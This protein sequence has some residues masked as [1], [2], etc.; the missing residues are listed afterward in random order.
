MCILMYFG[1]DAFPTREQ[2]QNAVNNNPDGFGWAIVTFGDEGIVT[3]HTMDAGEAI[4]GFLRDRA[5]YPGESA[6]F[7]ARIA[8]HGSTSLDNCHPFEV[9]HRFMKGK[10]HSAVSGEMIL[11]HN[12]MLSCGPGK[13]DDRSDT[14]I[15]ADDI[16][17]R[18][19]PHLDS[20]K[21]RR[22][23]EE[24]MGGSKVVVL[25]TDPAYRQQSYVFNSKLGH[26]L[27]DE[28]GNTL[29]YSNT[30]Y[31]KRT[32]SSYTYTPWPTVVGGKSEERRGYWW[33]E[34]YSEESG[35]H[36]GGYILA[37]RECRYTPAECGC[38]GT[39]ETSYM[40]TANVRFL[41]DIDEDDDAMAS[42]MCDGCMTRGG[43]NADAEC[44]YC[45]VMYCC[46]Q[47]KISCQ[48]W[49]ESGKLDVKAAVQALTSGASDPV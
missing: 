40:L 21:T 13:G 39:V 49:G 4:E 14:R 32:Y 34:G 7:H 18:R 5:M 3:G 25:T 46:N 48:C 31:M 29:W 41:S 6:I 47:P 30:S 20:A 12:G 33:E 37:C 15:L 45:G 2:L 19:F 44:T 23:F 17:M 43:I 38:S 11:A 36:Y 10:G 26:W 16:M 1:P 9:K 8:T 24:W 22:R 27:T 28:N 35:R 42:W